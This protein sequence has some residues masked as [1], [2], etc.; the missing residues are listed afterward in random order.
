MASSLTDITSSGKISGSGLAK[1]KIRGLP[2]IVFTIS[3][4]TSPPF[5][6]PRKTSLPIIASES[7]P[8]GRLLTNSSLYSFKSPFFIRES[9]KIPV[10][11]TMIMLSF[12]TPK[13][14]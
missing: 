11:S 12:L 9:V 13:R 8:S 2:A 5:D 14:T 10:E 3:G 4:D 6:N 7:P 1:A